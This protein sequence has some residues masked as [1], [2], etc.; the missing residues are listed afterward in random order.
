MLIKKMHFLFAL[1]ACV[2]GFQV[3]TLESVN[4]GT[5]IF[6][7]TAGKFVIITL[8]HMNTMK[9]SAIACNIGHFENISKTKIQEKNK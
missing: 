1:Q 7:T 5:E 3:V 9:H 8:E 4:G 6:R 2:D